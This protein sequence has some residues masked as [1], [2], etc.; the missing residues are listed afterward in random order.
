MSRHLLTRHKDPG[1][2]QSVLT[3]RW[4]MDQSVLTDRWETKE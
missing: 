2:G 4:E 3:D 1:D